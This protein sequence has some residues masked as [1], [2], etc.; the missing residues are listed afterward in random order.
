[1]KKDRRGKRKK[2][3]SQEKK[4][5]MKPRREKMIIFQLRTTSL[6][7]SFPRKKPEPA[8]TRKHTSSATNPAENGLN[9]RPLPLHRLCVHDKSRNSLPEIWRLLL[10]VTLP[11]LELR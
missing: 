6:L 2:E 8:A 3:K 4:K 7:Q 11:S 9:C 10:S 5:L 1:M